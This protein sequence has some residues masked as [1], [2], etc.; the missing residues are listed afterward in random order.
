LGQQYV[1][2][3]A[4]TIDPLQTNPQRTRG[5]PPLTPGGTMKKYGSSIRFALGLPAA[6]LI[7]LALPQLS[8]AQQNW[9]AIV[10]AQSADK[11]KQ[12]LAFLPNELWI[13]AGDTITWTAGADDIHTVTLLTAAQVVPSFQ[14]GCPGYS[15]SGSSFDGTACVSTPPLAKGQTFSVVFPTAGNYKLVCLVHPQMSGTIHVLD[16]SA[17]LPHTQDFYEDQGEAQRKL[18]FSESE[19]E[20]ANMVHE[21]DVRVYSGTKQIT[22]G[23]GERLATPGGAQ[24]G[25]L[26]R[27]LKGTIQVHAGDTVEWANRD[28]QEPHTI[29]FGQEPANLFLPSA[30][31]TVDADGA[32]HAT[33]SSPT[34]SVHSGF[35]EATLTDNPGAPDTG[36][37]FTRFRV[38][39]T[40][41]GRYPYICALHD[42]LG[43]VGTVVVLP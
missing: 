8:L 26:V 23:V 39:F 13:H 31:V 12:A 32:R 17:T 14:A 24:I 37:N 20:M 19:Q 15:P 10:G 36:L 18:L 4:L 42:N 29:T 21:D 3:A 41:P 35:I 11:A 27:F 33:L 40:G 38:T 6:L 25:S 9:Q 5:D 16:A 28:P 2:D 1:G 22:A 34:D 30:N 7:L 43:M